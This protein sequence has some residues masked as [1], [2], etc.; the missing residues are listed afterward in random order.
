[1]FSIFNIKSRRMI[2][3]K[4]HTIIMTIGPSNSGKSF[5]M[6]NN[7]IPFLENKNIKHKYLSTDEI[8]KSL[9]MEDLHIH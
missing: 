3:I 8:R 7:L 6:K 1:M 5:L 4:K 9:L 2:N